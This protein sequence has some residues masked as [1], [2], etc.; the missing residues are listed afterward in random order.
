MQEGQKSHPPKVPQWERWSR[1][2][3]SQ[4][5]MLPTCAVGRWHLVRWCLADPAQAGMLARAQGG[6]EDN[7]TAVPS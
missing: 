7:C 2:A 4:K 5:M 3:S 1:A 6:C